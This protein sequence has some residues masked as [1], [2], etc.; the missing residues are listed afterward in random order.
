MNA[1]LRFGA[2]LDSRRL[3]KPGSDS[4]ASAGVKIGDVLGFW[5]VAQNHERWTYP[6]LPFSRLTFTL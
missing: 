6:T 2:G 1:V 5:C 3:S 4:A